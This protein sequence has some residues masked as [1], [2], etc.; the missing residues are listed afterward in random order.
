MWG[1]AERHLP[2]SLLVIANTNHDANGKCSMAFG[3]RMKIMKE[4]DMGDKKIIR[5]LEEQ[6]SEMGSYE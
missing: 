5:S 1:D 6:A 2:F 4:R 3:W